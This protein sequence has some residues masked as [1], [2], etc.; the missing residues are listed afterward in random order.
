M[1]D[2]LKLARMGNAANRQRGLRNAMA[3]E[4]FIRPLYEDGMSLRAI[5]SLCNERRLR[6]PEDGT[7]WTH[8]MVTK[9]VRRLDLMRRP[10]A[11]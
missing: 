5:A 11:A 7:K 3:Y 10:V 4:W 9:I 2:Y 6:T 1:N 8:A